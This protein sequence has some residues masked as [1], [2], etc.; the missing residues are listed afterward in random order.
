MISPKVAWK[1]LTSFLKRT[2]SVNDYPIRIRRSSV[3]ADV[4]WGH[5]K[6]VAVEAQVINWWQMSGMGDTE[7]QALADLQKRF[8]ARRANGDVFP[9][10]GTGLPI[11]FAPGH[12]L[13]EHPSLAADFVRRILDFDPNEVFISDQS[14]LWDFHSN[15]DNSEYHEKILLTYGVDVSDIESG[16]LAAILERLASRGVSA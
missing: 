8:D 2:W 3:D 4:D 5:L 7:E 9:R 12:R 11:E 14:S 16:N 15:E 1:Y 13:A 10:P 6:P